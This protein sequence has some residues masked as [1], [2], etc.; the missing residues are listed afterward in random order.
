MPAGLRA[1][2]VLGVM[3]DAQSSAASG[4]PIVVLGFLADE[5]ARGLRAGS[6]SGGAVVVGGN[7][8]RAAALVVVVA[9]SVGATE[10]RALREATRR[11]TP[12]LAVQTDA[13]AQVSLPYVLATDIV[14]CPPGQGFPI[15]EIADV[16]AVRLGHD[17]VSLAARLPVLRA[18]VCRNLIGAASR[19]AAAVG[20]VPWGSAAH[21]PAM[22]LIQA[23][24]VL[25]LA[26]AHGQPIDGDRAAEIG[27]VAGT[28]L[29][30]RSLARRLP[31]WIPLV[32]GVTGYLGTRAI[33]E[34]AFKRAK[35]SVRSRT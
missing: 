25:D 10:E 32:G 12:T 11:G 21:F 15:S 3:R 31:S 28:G 9:G 6:E 19:Q 33:G 16:L 35:E 13:R 8:A 17:G 14:E 1:R 34:A 24:L 7:P 30:L 27:A 5:L 22:A 4:A 29:G 26:A 23:R 20:V 18:A 2:D